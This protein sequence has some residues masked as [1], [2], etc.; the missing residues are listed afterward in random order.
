MDL[1]AGYESSDDED[2]KEVTSDD[3]DCE[4]T[5]PVADKPNKDEAPKKRKSTAPKSLLPS[6]DSLFATTSGPAFLSEKKNEFKVAHFK[7]QKKDEAALRSEGRAAPTGSESAAEDRA[8]PANQPKPS[9]SLQPTPK[10]SKDSKDSKDRT[11]RKERVK[12]QRVRGQ[13][14]TV[15]P[16]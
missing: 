14:S 13:V 4:D 10:T 12:N 7:K 16:I 15:V 6:V 3:S 8:M 9:A 1:L 5:S 2:K 11:T